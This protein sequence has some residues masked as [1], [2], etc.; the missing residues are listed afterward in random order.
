MFPAATNTD[1]L[2]SPA[3]EIRGEAN[4]LVAM[5]NFEDQLVFGRFAKLDTGRIDNMDG[6]STPTIAGVVVRD[7][8]N[9]VEDAL[10]F[11]TAHTKKIDLNM[12]GLVTVEAIAGESPTFKAPIYA[13]NS[14]ASDMGKASVSSTNGVLTDA[15]F[16]E[17]VTDTVWLVLAK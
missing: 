12:V 11:A 5:T 10:A 2:K 6:S 15:V 13:R 8:S 3:G 14:G 1:Y 4:I 17:K 7:L 16:I 9:P